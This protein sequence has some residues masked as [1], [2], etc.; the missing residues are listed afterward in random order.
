MHHA[1][2]RRPC[3][4]A[5][6]DTSP[7]VV[8]CQIVGKRN[9]HCVTGSLALLSLSAPPGP[10]RLRLV[11][12]RR[13]CTFKL[14]DVEDVDRRVEDLLWNRAQ[15]AFVDANHL[16]TA[17]PSRIC[18][19]IRY[20]YSEKRAKR[21]TPALKLPTRWALWSYYSFFSFS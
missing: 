5:V 13:V 20:S 15:V 1:A 11:A 17:R 9:A 19:A 14:S 7:A 21:N 3:K 10:Q 2:R 12:A 16:K 4:Y 18:T 6:G 8:R